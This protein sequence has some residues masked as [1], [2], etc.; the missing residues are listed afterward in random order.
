VRARVSLFLFSVVVAWAVPARA[1]DRSQVGAAHLKIADDLA[2]VEVSVEGSAEPLHFVLDTGASISVL[3]RAV[4]REMSVKLGRRIKV[5]GTQGSTAGHTTSGFRGS[6]A[7]SSFPE[8][9][10]VLDLS[11]ISRMCHR[12]IDGLLG[13]DFFEGHRVQLDFAEGMLRIGDACN[14]VD[15]SATTLKLAR[16]ND[17]WCISGVVDAGRTQWF[18]IDTGYDGALAWWPGKARGS[19]ASDTSSVA[20]TIDLPE[21]GSSTVRL[22]RLTLDDVP[23]SLLDRRPFTGEAGLVGLSLLSQF[24]MTMEVDRRLLILEPGSN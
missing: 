10:L 3:D 6:L 23:T 22:D 8:K 4:A 19:I 18:R 20:A 24:R 17:A 12:R 1:E 21:R 7:G 16:R 2:W 14:A 9:L 13:A 5:L 11:R 15:D